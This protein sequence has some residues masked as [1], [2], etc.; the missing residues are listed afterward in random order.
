MVTGFCCVYYKCR[1]GG[2]VAAFCNVWKGRWIF[3]G[4]EYI[5]VLNAIVAWWQVFVI[6]SGRWT[7]TGLQYTKVHHASMMYIEVA[8]WQVSVMFGE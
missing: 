4:L 1:S 7:L 8:W 2:L 6:R 5:K 3:T